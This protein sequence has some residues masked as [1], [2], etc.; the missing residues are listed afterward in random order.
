MRIHRFHTADSL[1]RRF[2]FLGA[3][4]LVPLASPS[5]L[6]GLR[7]QRRV[8]ADLP[9]VA[10]GPTTAAAVRAAG[11]RLAAEA[12]TRDLDGVAAALAVLAP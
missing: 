5:A 12:P 2:V 7:A 6:E 10:L 11:L 3:K 1:E 8:P 9:L 4:L